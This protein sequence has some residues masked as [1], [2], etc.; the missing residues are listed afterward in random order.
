MPCGRFAEFRELMGLPRVFL[1][2]FTRPQREPGTSGSLRT[3]LISP[4]CV[5]NLVSRRASPAL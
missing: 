2:E 4:E 3:S 1:S 5:W